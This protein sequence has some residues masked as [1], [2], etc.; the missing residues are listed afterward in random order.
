MKQFKH[1]YI[2]QCCFHIVY[3]LIDCHN[4][5][6]YKGRRTFFHGKQHCQFYLFLPYQWWTSVEEELASLG[7]IRVA[8]YHSLQNSLTFPD[9]SDILQFSIPSDR[10]K[11]K[12]FLFFNLIMLTVS[13]QIWELFFKGKNLLP[14][15]ANSFLYE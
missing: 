5:H 9:F 7:A 13:L 12:S 2:L 11:K 15:G 10:S 4:L 8:T 3:L 6:S 1:C 14:K